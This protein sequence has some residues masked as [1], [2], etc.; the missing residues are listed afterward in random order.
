MLRTTTI[1]A[2]AL[3]GALGFAAPA[4]ANTLTLCK[5]TASTASGAG[6]GLAVA[7]WHKV[8]DA[9]YGAA[10]SN[11]EI[12]VNKQFSTSK[13]GALTLTVVSANPCRTIQVAPNP[14]AAGTAN[15]GNKP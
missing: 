4:A 14:P 9:T 10:W 7:T 11:F 12:A 8:V 13:L 5:P 15:S 1:A 2:I 6:R 3:A